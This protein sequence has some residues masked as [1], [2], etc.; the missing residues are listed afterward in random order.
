MKNY[1]LT[2]FES[3]AVHEGWASLTPEQMQE[4]LAK[5]MAFSQ[6]LVDEG[7]MLA[8]EGLSPNGK[9]IHANT[10]EVTDGPYVLAKEMVG[11]FYY[12]KAES[13]DEALEIAK[14]CPALHHGC[15]VEVRE[16]MEY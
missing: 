16:Q 10:L 12:Y 2:I 11:G 6:R 13:L 8:G 15:T 5:Y 3:A 1:V 4:G 9:V 14:D 7:R